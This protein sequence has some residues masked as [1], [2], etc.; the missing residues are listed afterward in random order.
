MPNLFPARRSPGSAAHGFPDTLRLLLPLHRL[1]GMNALYPYLFALALTL[2]LSL[3]SC[4]FV[5]LKPDFSV[6][7]DSLS[8]A[9][10]DSVYVESKTGTSAPAAPAPAA[11]PAPAAATTASPAAPA[12]AA[13]ASRPPFFSQ[14]QPAA[15][16]SAASQRQP[17]GS[18]QPPAARTS[19]SV[20]T[21]VPGDTLSRIARRHQV[22]LGSLAAA[23]GIDL[24]NPL[25]KAGQ[26]LHIP[27]GGAAIIAPPRSAS[28][29]A[30]AAPTA[31]PAAAPV[32]MA[33]APAPMLILNPPASA[34][35]PAAAAKPAPAAS[36]AA[37]PAPAGSYRVCAGDTLYRIALR[38]NISLQQLLEAN[39]LTEESAR[40]VR[41]GTLLTI[42]TPQ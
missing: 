31:A 22:P 38:H 2:P 17:L 1:H 3:T 25:I 10:F 27:Q 12:S 35:A 26:Q 39:N 23:N 15:R 8:P 19:S 40:S 18:S 32:P 21:V 24:Q 11:L 28:L 4:R 6:M 36:A 9:E 7:G 30:P 5:G 41:V 42:P 16:S 29:P 20:Y 37:A 33:P 13:S 14:Q 34:P